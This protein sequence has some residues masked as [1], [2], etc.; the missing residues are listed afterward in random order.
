[1]GTLGRLSFTFLTEAFPGL[2]TKG[3][4]GRVCT[5]MTEQ[6]SPAA[7][8]SLAVDFFRGIAL[9]D[10]Q[11]VELTSKELQLLHYLMQHRGE[12]LSRER[13]LEEVW[14]YRG[15]E[16]RTVDMHVALLRKKL[17]AD[18]LGSPRIAT[19]RGQ[20]YVLL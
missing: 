4:A 20:G 15:G 19:V 14:R 1:M 3:L 6:H 5:L 7:P 2:N 8:S 9:L 17:G 13:L 10:G 16:T 18:Y 11:S 12:V